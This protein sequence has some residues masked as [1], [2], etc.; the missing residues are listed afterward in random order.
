MLTILAI[1][2]LFLS[3]QVET[4]PYSD[5]KVLLKAGKIKDVSVGEQDITGTFITEGVDA[6]L[7]KPQVE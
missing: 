4:L 3:D 6:L 2:T 1:Q 5:F 7:S